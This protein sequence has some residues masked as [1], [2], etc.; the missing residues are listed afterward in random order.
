[1]FSLSKR[2]SAAL[3]HTSE[4]FW[5]SEVLYTV[6]APEAFITSLTFFSGN[7]SQNDIKSI[8]LDGNQVAKLLIS[9]LEI[10]VFI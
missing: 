10:V 3:K 9:T 8:L 5:P 1:M 2:N 7:L 4:A 6:S